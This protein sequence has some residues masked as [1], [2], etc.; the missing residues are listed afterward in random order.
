M[1][2]DDRAR[3]LVVELVPHAVVVGDDER[4]AGLGR[5]AHGAVDLDGHRELAQQREQARIF[6]GE[7]LGVV[8]GDQQAMRACRDK[9]LAQLL[10]ARRRV[11]AAVRKRDVEHL[12]GVLG[13][14]D[15][16]LDGGERFRRAGNLAVTLLPRFRVLLGR[17]VHAASPGST[18][19]C[20][21]Q[22]YTTSQSSAGASKPAPSLRSSARRR[23]AGRAGAG[24]AGASPLR[25]NIVPENSRR[26]RGWRGR[27][28]R[29][30]RRTKRSRAG[31]RR[32]GGGK[33]VGRRPPPE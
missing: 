27:P 20:R 33:K 1:G 13:D 7:E 26:G 9:E 28:S 4:V 3:L 22:P 30:A 11:E 31:G 16:L 12:D 15:H 29:A 25:K 8:Q 10:G 6:P 32:G 24:T 17:V 19:P 5:L 21:D 2:G 23:K 18:K 14:A